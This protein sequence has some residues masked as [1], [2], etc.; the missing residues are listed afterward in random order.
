MK[1]HLLSVGAD[2]KPPV[3]RNE[4]LDLVALDKADEAKRKSA[5]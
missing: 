4:F 2:L 3:T 1:G 5:M